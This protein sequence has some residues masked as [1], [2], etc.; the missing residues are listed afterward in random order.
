MTSIPQA[1]T[2][3]MSR[4]TAARRKPMAVAIKAPRMRMSTIIA[5]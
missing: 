4:V 1:I 2:D 3:I 5:G